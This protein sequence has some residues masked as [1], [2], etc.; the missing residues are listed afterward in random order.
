MRIISRKPISFA[1]P[2]SG[3]LKPF[4]IVYFAGFREREKLL[5]VLEAY[6][7]RPALFE[8]RQAGLIMPLPATD[9][10]SEFR[11][12]SMFRNLI[13]LPDTASRLDLL[14]IRNLPHCFREPGLQ[15]RSACQ[16]ILKDYDGKLVVLR[17]FYDQPEDS[18]G[19]DFFGSRWIPDEIIGGMENLEKPSLRDLE[20]KKREFR[21]RLCCFRHRFYFELREK[22]GEAWQS[23]PELY[24]SPD[25]SHLLMFLILAARTTGR[26]LAEFMDMSRYRAARNSVPEAWK[27][28]HK[29]FLPVDHTRLRE[30]NFTG[31]GSGE[32]DRSVF[33]RVMRMLES[34][35]FS[36]GS[37]RD[38]IPVALDETALHHPKFSL[39]NWNQVI[40]PYTEWIFPGKGIV[41]PSVE[42]DL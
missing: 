38:R 6:S 31:Q 15:F 18:A 25:E 21:L 3:M 32:D 1:Q 26:P 4:R 34:T 9:D 5:D 33:V 13:M 29:I 42:P 14:A 24:L 19:V 10:F 39:S 2:V 35:G 16:Q 37:R 20:V 17:Q 7:L 27:S 30:R 28:L 23:D 8:E 22:Q 41:L 36:A 12:C 40:G 11:F